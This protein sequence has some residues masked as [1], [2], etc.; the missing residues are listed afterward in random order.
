[1][2]WQKLCPRVWVYGPDWLVI[3]DQL[4]R[5]EIYWRGGYLE[6]LYGTLADVKKDV[7]GRIEEGERLQ[8]LEIVEGMGSV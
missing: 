8:A 7:A 2:K 6:D 4:Q 5:W 1:M 3:K